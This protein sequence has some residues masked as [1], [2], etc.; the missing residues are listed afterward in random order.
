ML[1]EETMT[2]AVFLKFL[3]RLIS[4]HPGQ[5]SQK[6]F[7]IVDNLKV[8]HALKVQAWLKEN[9]GYIEL[10]DLPAYSPDLNPDELLNQD[11]Q[12]NAC[13]NRLIYSTQKLKSDLLS[14]LRPIQKTPSKVQKFFLKPSGSYAS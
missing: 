6:I 3:K 12:A 10:F 8:H 5:K 2:V 14:Y 4:K 13:H 7:L 9:T 11:V 1:Y